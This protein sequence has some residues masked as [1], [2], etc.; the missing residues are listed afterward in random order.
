MKSFTRLV[1]AV[2]CLLLLGVNISGVSALS[3]YVSQNTAKISLDEKEYRD[4]QT[5]EQWARDCGCQTCDGFQI[6]T[7]DQK[8]HFAST[9][10]NLAAGSPILFVPAQMV[11]SSNAIKQE[12]GNGLDAAE[13]E[14]QRTNLGW[15]IPTFRLFCKI[16][17]EFEKGTDSPYYP[18]LNSLPRLFKNGAAMTFA[19]FEALPP[20]AANLSMKERQYSVSFQTVVEE[21]PFLSENTKVD[22][23]LLKWA[24]SIAVTRS[25]D[26]EGDKRI[27]P[28]GDYFNHGAEPEIQLS[29]DQEGNLV[30]F[31]A[32]DLPSGSPLRYCY[33]DPY[34]P[35]PLFARYGFLDESAPGAFC[36]LMDKLDE[37]EELGYGFSNLL[38]YKENGEVSPEVYDVLLYSILKEND[39]SGA[40]A[41]RNAVIQ[42]DEG[43][44]NGYHQQYFQYT[45]DALKKHVNS[46]LEELTQLSNKARTYNLDT[47]PR[48]PVIL[49]HNDHVRTTFERVR[50][51]LENM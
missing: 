20:Y 23:V 45:L 5:M 35:T 27:A 50:A 34:N 36:K 11:L 29:Y 18:W 13:A 49:R 32:R 43:T 46:F 21:V 16:L 48:V 19:C 38:F 22:S 30:V 8:N 37:M 51:N 6:T 31:A 15:Q 40:D 2:E 44:K 26:W 28:L 10:Q 47:H 41:F 25:F 17:F 42:K 4:I 33:A 14:L 39:P 24:Y 9:N 1:A 7:Y 3:S 12:F